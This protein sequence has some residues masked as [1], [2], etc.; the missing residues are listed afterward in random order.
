MND[1]IRPDDIVEVL[2][3]NPETKGRKIVLT[4]QNKVNQAELK[5]CVD[6]ILKA[7]GVK[8]AWVSDKSEMGDFEPVVKDLNDVA[9]KLGS[10]SLGWGDRI[11]EVAERMYNASKT[12]NSDKT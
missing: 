2:S 3:N 6:K 12:S 11:H 8:S 5:P 1:P 7:I 4:P 9:V 10:D